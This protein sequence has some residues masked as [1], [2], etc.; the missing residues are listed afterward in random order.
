VPRAPAA[1]AARSR[2]STT[3]WASVEA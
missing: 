3:V 2:C 1:A